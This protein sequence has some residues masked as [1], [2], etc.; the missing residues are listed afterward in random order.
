MNSIADKKQWLSFDP[1]RAALYGAVLLKTYLAV[2]K[3]KYP[4]R[5]LREIYKYALMLYNGDPHEMHRYWEKIFK[6]SRKLGLKIY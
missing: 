6:H 3:N 1:L 2:A 5:S 4:R